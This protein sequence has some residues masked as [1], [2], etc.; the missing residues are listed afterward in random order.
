M[1]T[2]S[3]IV[4]KNN[5]LSAACKNKKGKNVTSKLALGKCIG[6]N[7]GQLTFGSN[8]FDKSSKNCKLDKK[9]MA[10]LSKNAKGKWIN[11]RINLD[12]VISNI[13]GLLKC[14]KVKSKPAKKKPV[15][16]IHKHLTDFQKSCQ[17]VKLNN[18]V[19]SGKCLNKK[20]K[21][22]NARINLD[23]CIGNNDGK[24]MAHM[25]QYNKSSKSCK[26]EESTMKCLSK[27]KK[28]KYISSQFDL[29][30]IVGNINGRLVC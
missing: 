30:K 3:S 22:I 21:P 1:K 19:L 23:R 14:D 11:S 13:N 10:C 29:S 26:L 18:N 4:L 24:L 6:N 2:C 17:N 20:Q 5:N 8:E 25:K 28:G 15:L 12:K 9:A 16:K 27:N 7:N